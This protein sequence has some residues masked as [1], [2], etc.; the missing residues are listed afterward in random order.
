MSKNIVYTRAPRGVNKA[1][2]TGKRVYGL[3][4]PPDQLELKTVV[5][6]SIKLDNSSFGI[7]KEEAEKSN[8]E[9]EIIIREIIEKYVQKVLKKK[10][11]A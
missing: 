11:T 8:V 9:Y 1:L 3:I 2:K 10:Q 4:P 5:E 6:I 7:L